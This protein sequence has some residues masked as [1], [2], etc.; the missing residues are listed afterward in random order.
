MAFNP[1]EFVIRLLKQG[2][3]AADAK[4]EL[5]QLKTTAAQTGTTSEQAAL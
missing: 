1:I 2:T 5:E 4:A 3:G